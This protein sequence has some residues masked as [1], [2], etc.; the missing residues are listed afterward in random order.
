MENNPETSFEKVQKAVNPKTKAAH[1][2]DLI[3]QILIPFV[4]LF[5][6]IIS[7]VIWLVVNKIGTSYIWADIVVI[8]TSVPIMVVNLI[9]IIVMIGIIFLTFV[10]NKEIPPLTY[11]TQLAIYKIKNQ[12]ERGADIS[13]MPLIQIKSYLATLD[14]IFALFK[15]KNE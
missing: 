15:G 13:A 10:I 9:F 2:K 11:K 14:A 3:L 6:A 5:I 7:M 12:V 1:K 4:L 8:L